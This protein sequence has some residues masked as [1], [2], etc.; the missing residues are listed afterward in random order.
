ML[1]I[2]LTLLGKTTALNDRI[3][4]IWWDIFQDQGQAALSLCVKILIQ[5]FV[6]LVITSAREREFKSV[7][8]T[9]KRDSIKKVIEKI[10]DDNTIVNRKTVD[11]LRCHLC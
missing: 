6:G 4:K 3:G 5:S 2:Q 9:Y 11:Q 8:Y 10:N 1:V 7:Q